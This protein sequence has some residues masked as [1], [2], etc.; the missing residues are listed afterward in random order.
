MPALVEALRKVPWLCSADDVPCLK[1]LAQG[2]GIPLRAHGLVFRRSCRK[3]IDRLEV[4]YF[5]AKFCQGKVSIGDLRV[6]VFP[7]LSHQKDKVA[8]I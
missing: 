7:C 8:L 4:P 3:S 2:T 5:C 6:G 1:K